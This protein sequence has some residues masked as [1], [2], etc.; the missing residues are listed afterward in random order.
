MTFAIGGHLG[1]GLEST[2]CPQQPTEPLCSG[3]APDA[4]RVQAP[5]VVPRY[6]PDGL[7]PAPPAAWP[8]ALQGSAEALPGVNYAQLAAAVAPQFDDPQTVA[9]A[10]TRAIVVIHRVRHA[11]AWARGAPHGGAYQAR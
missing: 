4:R 5:P 10:Q 2:W 11:W 3:E 7:P 1:P 9:D 6:V 8:T